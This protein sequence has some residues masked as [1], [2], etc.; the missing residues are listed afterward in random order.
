MS[1]V[2][3]RYGEAF[4]RA[5]RDAWLQSEFNQREYCE[6]YGVPLKTFGN[7]QGSEQCRRFMSPSSAPILR[8]RD[9]SRVTVAVVA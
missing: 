9:H 6:A 1:S 8:G 7:W 3:E 4:W 5:H 2:R